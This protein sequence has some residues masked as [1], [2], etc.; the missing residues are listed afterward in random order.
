MTT[1]SPPRTEL[2]KALQR[3]EDLTAVLAY[4]RTSALRHRREIRSDRPVP[5]EVSEIFWAWAQMCTQ[6]LEQV[7]DES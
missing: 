5:Q 6:V 3:I 1:S 4:M 2:E 7:D